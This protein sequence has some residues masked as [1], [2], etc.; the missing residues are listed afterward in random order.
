MARSWQSEAL[1]HRAH[2]RLIRL[3][4]AD[5]DEAA[6]RGARNRRTLSAGKRL[7]VLRM[8]C[9]ALKLTQ[10]ER[11]ACLGWNRS[12]TLGPGE[13]HSTD[14]ARERLKLTQDQRRGSFSGGRHCRC[15]R[16]RRLQGSVRFEIH[17][18]N[19]PERVPARRWD[20]CVREG[21]RGGMFPFDVAQQAPER[22]LELFL[23]KSS[24]GFLSAVRYCTLCARTR[25]LLSIH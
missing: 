13:A 14:N 24:R 22:D 16:S 4:Q 2:Q 8:S 7:V 21:P 17:Q 1:L 23:T 20:P 12:A 3:V 9:E 5:P 11:S 10:V 18:E 25:F 15:E 19:R 6:V